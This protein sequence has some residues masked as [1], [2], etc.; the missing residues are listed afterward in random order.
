[1]DR[2][3]AGHLEARERSRDLG[4]ARLVTT[5]DVLGEVLTYFS[6]GPAAARTF[7]AETVRGILDDPRIHVEP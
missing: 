2:G 7:A 4:D 3:D 5:D 6:R 1:M